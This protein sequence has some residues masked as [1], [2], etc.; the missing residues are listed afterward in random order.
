MG[1]KFYP[2]QE[3]LHVIIIPGVGQVLKQQNWHPLGKCC[4]SE[5]QVSHSLFSIG[6]QMFSHVLE[7]L[8]FE[9]VGGKLS[10]DVGS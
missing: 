7:N 3:T 10:Q 2:T 9:A 8:M 6:V 1:R 5:L 4:V